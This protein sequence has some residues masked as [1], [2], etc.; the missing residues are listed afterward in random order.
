MPIWYNYVNI[1][2]SYELNTMNNVTMT[3]GMHTFHITAY[4]P[5]QICLSHCT[6]MSHCTSTIVYTDPTFLCTSIKNKLQ[7]ILTNYCKI[8]EKNKYTPQMPLT[9]HMPKLLDMHLWGSMPIFMP[10]KQSL[11]SKLWSVGRATDRYQI[12]KDIDISMRDKQL[13]STKRIAPS[14]QHA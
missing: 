11:W 3:T 5:E 4:A 9:C 1:S 12:G 10:H 14:C 13:M 8:C 7:Y 6:Y 2:T